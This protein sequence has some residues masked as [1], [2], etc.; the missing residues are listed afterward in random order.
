[1]W[2]EVH[3]D[4]LGARA[5]S[6]RRTLPMRAGLRLFVVSTTP[7]SV[8]SRPTVFALQR[9]EYFHELREVKL[10]G[11]M[12]NSTPALPIPL[13]PDTLRRSR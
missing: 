10:L 8:A 9:P 2:A 6:L 4:A 12:L 3:S 11:S 1:M 5:T 7:P 13:R